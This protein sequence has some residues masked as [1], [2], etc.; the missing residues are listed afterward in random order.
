MVWAW[1]SNSNGQL[2]LEQNSNV[3]LPRKIKLPNLEENEKILKIVC[4][5]SYSAIVNLFI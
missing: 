5:W 4:G 1:G 3:I 2:G